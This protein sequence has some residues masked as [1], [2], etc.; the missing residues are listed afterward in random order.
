MVRKSVLVLAT[1]GLL[2]LL[3][4][5]VKAN[6]YWYPMVLNSGINQPLLG[7][8]FYHMEKTTQHSRERF[9]F[10]WTS[11][12]VAI[13]YYVFTLANFNNW[14]VGLPNTPYA[15]VENVTADADRFQTNGAN[16]TWVFVWYNPS[17]VSTQLVGS[18][19]RYRWVEVEGSIPGFP[20]GA[21][22]FGVIS[23]VALTVILRKKIRS[24]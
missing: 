2:F 5:T 17:L 9:D 19:E 24:E 6:G 21:I 3:V 4:P 12:I 1:L 13:N 16:Q 11:G 15:S 22:V 14:S 18:Y 23:A 7:L 8:Q 20:W 10:N